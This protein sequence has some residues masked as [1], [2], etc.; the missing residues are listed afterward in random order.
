MIS[1]GREYL[2][3]VARSRARAR[4]DSRNDLAR[5]WKICQSRGGARDG[6]GEEGGGGGG[7]GTSEISRGAKGASL[8]G[9]S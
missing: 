2:H 8:D 4:G 6:D 3:F 5:F 7:G 1:R 9:N